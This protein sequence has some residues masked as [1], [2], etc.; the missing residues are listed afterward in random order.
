[1]QRGRI[2]AEQFSAYLQE[3]SNI[4]TQR[5]QAIYDNFEATDYYAE[6]GEECDIGVSGVQ[7]YEGGVNELWQFLED[8]DP[9]HL[10]NGLVQIWEGNQRIIEAMRINRENR[11]ALALLWDQ[12]QDG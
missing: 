4:L 6:N 8:G 10:S 2:T 7:S 9:D 3:L 5:A 1:M 11:E 12:L